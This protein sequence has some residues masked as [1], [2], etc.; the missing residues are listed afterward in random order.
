MVAPAEH[1]AEMDAQHLARPRAQR[2]RC[3]QSARSD[4]GTSMPTSAFGSY[5]VSQPASSSFH[6]RS[7]SSVAIRGS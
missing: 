3:A 5:V 1:L 4:E 6:V 7:M 2:V